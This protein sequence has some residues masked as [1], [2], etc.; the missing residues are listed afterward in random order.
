M[1]GYDLQGW[2]GGAVL[3]PAYSD[4][5]GYEQGGLQDRKGRGE[6]TQLQTN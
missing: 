6:T 5:D 2:G 3:I 1:T 4:S